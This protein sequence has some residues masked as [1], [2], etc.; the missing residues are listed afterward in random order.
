MFDKLFKTKP[1]LIYLFTILGVL[2][3]IYFGYPYFVKQDGFTDEDDEDNEDDK[4]D[5]TIKK[6]VE[7]LTDSGMENDEPAY[8]QNQQSSI[9]PF[10]ATSSV[11][12]TNP[13]VPTDDNIENFKDTKDTK[14]TKD[15]T[16]ITKYLF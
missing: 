3:I 4:D 13:G 12:P 7:N 15:I 2:V 6:P 5:T 9:V 16:N 14:D 1:Y 8:K 10:P 11:G